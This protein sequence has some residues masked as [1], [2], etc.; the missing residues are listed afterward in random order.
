MRKQQREKARELKVGIYNGA[1]LVGIE[2]MPDPRVA[3]C[4]AYN[5]INSS[6]KAHPVSRATS[7][8]SAKRLSE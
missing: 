3:F 8:A 4:Q 2:N 5:A 1:A 6:R 7:M